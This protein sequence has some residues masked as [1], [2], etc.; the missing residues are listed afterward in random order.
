MLQINKIR[1]KTWRIS[2]DLQHGNMAQ[3]WSVVLRQEQ[4]HPYYLFTVP[5]LLPQGPR[6]LVCS[7][8]PARSACAAQSCQAFLQEEVCV[9]KGGRQRSISSLTASRPRTPGRS[10]AHLRCIKPQRRRTLCDLSA[11]TLLRE[12]LFAAWG[13]RI[14]VAASPPTQRRRAKIFFQTPQGNAGEEKIQGNSMRT[15]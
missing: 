5:P 1:K 8:R 11:L 3:W 6:P 9:I 4:R 13:T 2:Y 7:S 15:W 14:H 12:I 10:A